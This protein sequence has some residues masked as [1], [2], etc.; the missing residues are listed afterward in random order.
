MTATRGSRS[1]NKPVR[2]RARAKNIAPVAQ[3]LAAV[4]EIEQTREALREE[5]RVKL[6][7]VGDEET[8]S[9]REVARKY[10]LAF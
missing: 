10:G 6:G 2:R 4:M 8:S 1:K 3:G 7:V 9:F 5:A